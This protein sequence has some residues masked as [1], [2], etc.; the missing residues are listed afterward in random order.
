MMLMP[1][2]FV[3]LYNYASI[4]SNT[5]K[6]EIRRYRDHQFVVLEM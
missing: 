5:S 6:S 4:A 3:F 2:A 1:L